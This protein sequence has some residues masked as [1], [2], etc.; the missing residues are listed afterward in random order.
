MSNALLIHAG[1]IG[2][3]IM[4]LRIV[5]ALRAA[6]AEK[7]TVLGKPEIASIALPGGGV[8]AVLDINQGGYHT[9]FSAE[10]SLPSAIAKALSRFDLAVD[11]LGGPDGRPIVKLRQAGIPRVIG[12]DPRPRPTWAGHI[13]DQWLA[14]LRTAGI[15]AC[16]GPPAIRLPEDR[17][18]HGRR[19]LEDAA[20]RQGGRFV[21]VHPGSGS[22][23][24]CWPSARFAELAQHL[25][26]AGHSVVFILGP[27]EMERFILTEITG[28]NAIAPTITNSS[29]PSGVDL[30]A[31]AS[32][33]IGNDSGM[34][35]LAAALGTPIV[36][37]FGPTSPT[38]W[39][40]MGDRV[41]CVSPDAGDTW[42][43]VD[44][45][46]RIIPSPQ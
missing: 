12:I 24:K 39:M 27:V 40:P 13:S 11:M 22:R 7:V 16:P 18:D 14:D 35:H 21:I 30:L 37:I 5:A 41:T 46:F 10:S 15:D 34:S 23:Q 20:G 4:S 2:D 44:E 1:A 9:L 8:D 42:P 38:L 31:A 29:L 36:T 32:L 25:N 19:L 17:I 33:Y 28:L 43:T 3:F 6:G 45:V 26:A